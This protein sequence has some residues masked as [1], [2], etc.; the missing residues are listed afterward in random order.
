M[1]QRAGCEKEKIGKQ[2][3]LIQ[4]TRLIFQMQVLISFREGGIGYASSF[5]SNRAYR[6]RLQGHGNLLRKGILSA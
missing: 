3:I 2:L 1:P 5:F 4:R 6:F